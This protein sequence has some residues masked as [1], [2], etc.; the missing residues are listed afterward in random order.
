MT[1]SV[2]GRSSVEMERDPRAL[3]WDADR[4]LTQSSAEVL[5]AWLVEGENYERWKK[6]SQYGPETR[7][8]LCEEINRRLSAQRIQHRSY[9]AIS[10]K[11][12]SFKQSV[13]KA[14]QLLAE[15]GVRGD[16]FD[17]CG[18]RLRAQ[19]LRLCPALELLAPV[20]GSLKQRRSLQQQATAKLLLRVIDLSQQDEV[21]KLDFLFSSQRQESDLEDDEGP[22]L[23]K[24]S[25]R[26]KANDSERGYTL[27]TPITTR[28]TIPWGSDHVDGKSSLDILLLWIASGSNCKAQKDTR[29]AAPCQEKR[30]VLRSAG[31]C[32]LMALA[33]AHTK[34]FGRRS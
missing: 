27:I 30:F 12:L 10:R 2:L 31:S 9:G 13:D 24:L 18:R 5:V 33:I 4:V 19:V 11:I 8:G 14:H 3:S 21:H 29:E 15:N 17:D 22:V 34:R 25:T 23:A 28:Q 16:T 7:P 32:V 20:L 26:A 1:I 6:A